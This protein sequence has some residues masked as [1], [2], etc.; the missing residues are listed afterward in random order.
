MIFPV[1]SVSTPALRPTQPHEQWVPGV[2]P[3]A[4][5]RPERDADHLHLVPRARMSRSYTSPSKRHRG[6]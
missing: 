5:A 2:L 6:V 3:A 4:K 1:A